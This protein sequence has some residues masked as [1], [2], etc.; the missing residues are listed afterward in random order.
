MAGKTAILSVRITG[1]A[2]GGVR[3]LA[4]TAAAATGLKRVTSSVKNAVT[5]MVR[6]TPKIAAVAVAAANVGS[7]VVASAGGLLSFGASLASVAPAAL[8]LP[9]VLAGLGAG[10]ERLAPAIA[11]VADRFGDLVASDP[12]GLS[13][14]PD[15][16]PLARI[17][18]SAF[19]GYL[20]AGGRFSRA[21]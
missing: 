9:G 11:D 17:I 5:G 1:N 20:A 7:A 6:N 12:A 18:A 16:V 10:A 3:A 21:S 19:D 14:R 4:E 2:K 15:G 13:I 8:A